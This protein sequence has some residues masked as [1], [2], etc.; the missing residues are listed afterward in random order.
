MEKRKPSGSRFAA[1]KKGF[2]SGATSKDFAAEPLTATPPLAGSGTTRKD[3]SRPRGSSITLTMPGS[4]S[5]GSS[6]VTS[7]S[8]RGVTSGLGLVRYQNRMGPG[9][10]SARSDQRE[11]DRSSREMYCRYARSCVKPMAD[12]AAPGAPTRDRNSCAR[13]E[14]NSG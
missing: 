10:A 5:G 11:G 6:S 2:Q 3:N 12:E 14:R 1:T 7:P 8:W 9:R 13:P 4:D